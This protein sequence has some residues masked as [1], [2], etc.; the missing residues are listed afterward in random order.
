MKMK[1]VF[2]RHILDRGIVILGFLMLITIGVYFFYI[3]Q[4]NESVA[5]IRNR[6]T[7]TVN[8]IILLP[9]VLLK[10]KQFVLLI[11]DL[12]TGMHTKE[13]VVLVKVAHT[14]RLSINY[15]KQYQSVHAVNIHNNKK[16]YCF[17]DKDIEENENIQRST[18]YTL[19]MLKYS[20]FV[21][22]CKI[23]KHHLIQ[24]DI[25]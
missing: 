19:T 20:N 16:V 1:K 15:K 3:V 24:T 14:E 23:G 12:L 13:M 6:I 4:G 9:I 17:C 11:T 5:Q 21:I 2:H 10:I 25:C 7:F 22:Q 8:I 18:H